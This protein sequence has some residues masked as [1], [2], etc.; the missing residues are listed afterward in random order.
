MYALN[1][2]ASPVTHV[3]VHEPGL[4]ALVAIEAE[5]PRMWLF[6]GALKGANGRE[7]LAAAS[8]EHM[9]FVALLRSLGVEVHYLTDLL[10]AKSAMIQSE[11]HGALKGAVSQGLV[12]Q[13]AAEEYWQRVIQDSVTAALVGVKLPYDQYK[14][15]AEAGFSALIPNPNAYFA[16]D[17]F[18]I[19]GH[20]FVSMKPAT[21]Q[22][23]GEPW[24]WETALNPDEERL[25]RMNNIC[26][27]GDIL[28]SNGT[29]YVGIGT[30]T[31][32]EAAAE[33]AQYTAARKLQGVTGVVAVVKPDYGAGLGLSH[34]AEL[35]CIHLDTV[36]MTLPHSNVVGNAEL[37][38]KCYVFDP[39]APEKKVGLVA[40]INGQGLTIISSD[41]MEQY[42]L[43]PNVLPVNG[44]AIST[45]ANAKTNQALRDAGYSVATFPSGTL[46]GGS[47]SAHCMSKTAVRIA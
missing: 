5:D 12:P 6:D 17:P 8:S 13:D 18:A 25:V 2:D 31:T 38:G 9:Q 40:H 28:M 20:S 36:M 14:P 3:F 34:T 44:T 21:W 19:V 22:R 11:L 10:R 29:A 35:P 32:A 45:T 27:G 24:I 39:K 30:R 46:L 7:W 42:T 33:L 15:L 26:E 41:P 16:R 47:G 37:M 43:A 1:D 23:S 4:E